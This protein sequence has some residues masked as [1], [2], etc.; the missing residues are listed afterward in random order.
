MLTCIHTDGTQP[1]LRPL[2]STP[3]PSPIIPKIPKSRPPVYSQ[4]FVALMRS[5]L[6]RGPGEINNKWL[7]QP[8]GMPERVDPE[9]EEA[10]MLGPLSKRREVNIRWRFYTKECDK[11]IPPLDLPDLDPESPL[12][13]EKRTYM[14]DSGVF[15]QLLQ[16]ARSPHRDERL[17]RRQ[18]KSILAT[19]T[20]PTPAQ[21]LPDVEPLPV[22]VPRLIRRRYQELLSRIP[23]LMPPLKGK[24][25]YNIVAHPDAIPKAV[26]FKSTLFREASASDIAWMD[27]N[28]G[29]DAK[30]LDKDKGNMGRPKEE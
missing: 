15:E 21:S 4:E 9:S 8:F 13:S 29:P 7:R 24:N 1:L 26:R 10:K 23:V 11:I 22:Q 14:G 16:I 5:D 17:T 25:G 28:L 18:R 20:R 19:G 6:G 27:L 3:Q 30:K 12:P 2:P